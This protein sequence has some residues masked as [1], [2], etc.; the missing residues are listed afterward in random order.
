M[1]VSSVPIPSPPLRVV[2]VAPTA[3]HDCQPL[4][5]TSITWLLWYYELVR[6]PVCHLTSLT[7]YRLVGHT[8]SKE[9]TG[10]PKFM[11]VPC[12][13]LLLPWT[14]SGSQCLA[15]YDSENAA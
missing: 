3:A 10:S 9:H 13:T 8:L 2:D 1:S 4:P 15:C 14:P 6:L 5:S 7:V 12:V 11:L